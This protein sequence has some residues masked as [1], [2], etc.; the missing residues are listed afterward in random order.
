M[1]TMYKLIIA[2]CFTLTGFLLGLEAAQAQS[3]LNARCY[4]DSCSMSPG[5]LSVITK[6]GHLALG[7]AQGQ[8]FYLFN[9]DRTIHTIRYDGDWQ[10]SGS[11]T[12]IYKTFSMSHQ[13]DAG[14]IKIG[15][16]SDTNTERGGR[17]M[18]HGVDQDR[19][20][21]MAILEAANTSKVGTD[22]KG[23]FASVWTRAE[24][25]IIFGT[26]DTPR[27]HVTGQGDLNFLKAQAEQPADKD[28]IQRYLKIQLQGEDFYIELK[29]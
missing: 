26:H 25:P 20:P 16:G 13:S 11:G 22:G 17:I 12:D 6:A 5:N 1:A 27:I 24:Q 7:A 21:G 9:G 29:R 23:A 28:V 10:V 14:R 19:S 2:A 15:G 3:G 4:Q 8:N 18:L